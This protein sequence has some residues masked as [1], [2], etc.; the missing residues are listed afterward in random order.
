MIREALNNVQKHS[1]ASRVAVSMDRTENA[2]VI[3]IE[4]DGT[5]FPLAGSYSLD[6]L[7]ALHLGP[8]SIKRRV[9]DLGGEMTLESRPGHGAGIEIRIPL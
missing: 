4:D 9:R 7:D 5:G 2:L 3:S 8:V 6:E 1:K